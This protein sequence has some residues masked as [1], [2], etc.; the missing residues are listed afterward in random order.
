MSN[1]L[2]TDEYRREINRSMTEKQWQQRVEMALRQAGALV[3]HAYDSRKSA[4]GYPD[5]TAVMPDGRLLFAEL[6]TESVKLSEHQH[7]WLAALTKTSRAAGVPVA[8]SVL[9]PSDYEYLLD[10]IEGKRWLGGRL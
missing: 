9:R 1:H 8:V 2:T 10:W 6:K 7:R 5:V 4:P 3:Y